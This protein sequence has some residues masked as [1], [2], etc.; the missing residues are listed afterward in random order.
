MRFSV[1][2]RWSEKTGQHTA[3]VAIA[4]RSGGACVLDGYPLILLL[5]RSGH[6]LAFTYSHSGDQMIT[7][8][9]PKAVRV[10]VGGVAYFAFNKYR[11]DVRALAVAAAVRVKLPGGAGTRTVHLPHHPIIDFCHESPS[12]I[13]TVSPIE[14]RLADAAARP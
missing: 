7:A 11:C 14:P 9:P 5:D 12:R 2:A 13:V 8:R 10:K 3:T 1:G 4:N 6:E